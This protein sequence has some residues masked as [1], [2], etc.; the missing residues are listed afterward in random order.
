MKLH[1]EP[2]PAQARLQRVR[3]T[4]Y[5]G[6]LAGVIMGAGNALALL[7]DFSALPRVFGQAAAFLAGLFTG[8]TTPHL[9]L[10]LA[11]MLLATLV[12]A[13]VSTL[14]LVF[15]EFYV[16]HLGLELAL[17]LSLGRAIL[18]SLGGM[19]FLAGGILLVKFLTRF[20]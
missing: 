2:T 7:G 8:R 17:D 6:V 12:S 5:A 13:A 16:D 15:P 19:P 11:A 1:W 4:A 3:S 20:D 14:S 10:S 9:S 18:T